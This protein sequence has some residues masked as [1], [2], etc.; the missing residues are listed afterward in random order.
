MMAAGMMPPRVALGGLA[1]TLRRGGGL[2]GLTKKRMGATV[3]LAGRA[4]EPAYRAG[5][6]LMTGEDPAEDEGVARALEAEQKATLRSIQAKHASDTAAKGRTDPAGGTQQGANQPY[7]GTGTTGS[8][9]AETGGVTTG[10]PGAGRL[11]VNVPGAGWQEYDPDVGVREAF[12]Q[13][14]GGKPDSFMEHRTRTADSRYRDS[15]GR[16]IAPAQE[17]EPSATAG[18]SWSEGGI[19]EAAQLESWDTYLK[20]R[21]AEQQ[22]FEGGMARGR[23]AE[24]AAEAETARSELLA[25]EPMTPE[26]TKLSEAGIKSETERAKYGQRQATVARAMQM[27]DELRMKPE[28][29]AATP[30]QQK[31]MVEEIQFWAALNLSGLTETNL[32]P[33]PDPYS[34]FGGMSQTPGEKKPEK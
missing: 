16:P 14:R 19:P 23:A 20:M 6:I 3:D 5:S 15:Y 9:T 11:R 21:E 1:E 31:R 24:A 32:M 2:V 22:E 4:V 29:R 7:R 26:I 28:Y 33:R 17:S 30:E 10:E 8:R 18:G 12:A 13:A 34:I 25:E 27:V